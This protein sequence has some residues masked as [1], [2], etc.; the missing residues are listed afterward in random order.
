MCGRYTLVDPGRFFAE[1]SIIEKR[2]TLE[3]RFNVAPDQLVPVVRIAPPEHEATVEMLLWGLLPG[4]ATDRS[5]RGAACFINARV[6]TVATKP[7]FA[8]AFRDRRCVLMAD[9][10]Y[11]WRKAEKRRLPYL[12]RTCDSA[13][14]AIAGIW[15]PANVALG[16]K[17]DSCAII[18]VPALPPVDSLHDRMPAILRHGDVGMWLDPEM[19]DV[20][21]LKDVLGRG[22]SIELFMVPVGLRVNNPANDDPECIQPAAGDGVDDG[23]QRRLF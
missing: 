23:P 5:K 14:L 18:T 12:V 10:F 2:P 11:E 20:D 22:S 1:F 21:A 19:R 9:G 8:E 15:E 4:W 13:P 17:A 16:R 3:P 7:A 6:E